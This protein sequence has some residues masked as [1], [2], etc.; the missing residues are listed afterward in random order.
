MK[1]HIKLVQILMALAALTLTGIFSTS[2]FA[3]DGSSPV[4]PSLPA[5]QSQG[6]IEFLTGG[7]GKDESEAI[8]KEGNSWPLMLELAQAATPGAQYISDVQITIKD[9]S[10]NTV[11][12]IGAEGPYVLVK[13]PPGKYSLDAIYESTKLHRHLDIKK[14]GNRKITLLWPA[15]K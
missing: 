9:K 3:Q 1:I 7:I 10:G 15:A 4:N 11:L 5:V 14:G 12:D 8:L 6:P 13:L 2:G